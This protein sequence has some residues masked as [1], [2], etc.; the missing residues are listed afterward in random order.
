MGGVGVPPNI[1]IAGQD[2]GQKSATDMMVDIFKL[3]QGREA[4]R[5]EGEG[6]DA[7]KLAREM[8]TNAAIMENSQKGSPLYVKAMG[9]LV[10]AMGGDPSQIRLPPV[11]AGKMIE[12]TFKRVRTIE[13][14]IA[15][16]KLHPTQ[17]QVEIQ[18]IMQ[19]T[20]AGL[21]TGADVLTPEVEQFGKDMGLEKVGQMNVAINSGMQTRQSQAQS[22]TL[23]RGRMEL[24]DTIAA[25]A[26]QRSDTFSRERLKY[27]DELQRGRIALRAGGDAGDELGMVKKI[28]ETAFSQS[29]KERDRQAE[30]AEKP[31]IDP[32]TGK[33]IPR[34]GPGMSPAQI[35][36]EAAGFA[37][38]AVK[39]Y[40]ADRPELAKKASVAAK[41][42]VEA[43]LTAE[44][45][46]ILGLAKSGATDELAT[47]I[48]PEEGEDR[49][50][51]GLYAMGQI[52]QLVEGGQMKMDRDTF[53]AIFRKAGYT[54]A[55]ILEMFAQSQGK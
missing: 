50:T 53:W 41:A 13:E 20:Y 25:R 16:G 30:R 27:S 48:A 18:E 52:N 51:A 11:E 3:K 37:D 34:T 5:L 45:S 49:V 9:G 12:S 10:S 38:D 19:A 8:R 43:G 35:A 28:R 32:V 21:T 31:E 1:F 54:D 22:D 29:I 47:M 26:A 7:Q 15:S 39:K 17:G 23:T 4:L 2:Q 40:L 24:G 46:T 42:G 36:I 33:L 14:K 44:A 6:L 55:E